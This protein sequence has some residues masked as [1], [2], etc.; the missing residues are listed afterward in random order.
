MEC[1]GHVLFLGH[2]QKVDMRAYACIENMV[3]DVSEWA[4]CQGVNCLPNTHNPSFHM[5]ISG[6]NVVYGRNHTYK[7]T[8][9]ASRATNVDEYLMEE[10]V[11]DLLH[12]VFTKYS[13]SGFQES[14]GMR[15]SYFVKK[16]LKRSGNKRW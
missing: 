4:A 12:M 11:V 3:Y 8:S 14:T 6:K 16:N 1:S 2:S 5:D 13:A 7:G 15:S 9:H 10:E